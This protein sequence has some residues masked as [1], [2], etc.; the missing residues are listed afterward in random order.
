MTLTPEERAEMREVLTPSAQEYPGG[1][2][3]NMLRLLEWGEA[4][5]ADAAALRSAVAVLVNELRISNERGDSWREM[6]KTDLAKL[7]AAREQVAQ[8]TAA[9][10]RIYDAFKK[11]AEGSVATRNAFEA[12]AADATLAAWVYG[13]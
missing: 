6:D 10:E 2:S 3:W 9:L 13:P 12:V 1:D 4:Q 11:A 8:L 7:E 5:E